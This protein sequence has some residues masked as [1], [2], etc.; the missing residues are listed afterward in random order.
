M[1]GMG[2]MTGWG[3]GLISLLVLIVLGLGIGALV[4]HLS[5]RRK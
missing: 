1:I 3:M 2:G 5:R 4:K